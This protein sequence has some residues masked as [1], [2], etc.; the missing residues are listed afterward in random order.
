MLLE[1]YIVVTPQR[2]RGLALL[3]QM[4]LVA[5]IVRSRNGKIICS[6]SA[7]TFHF[8]HHYKTKK[9]NE[10]FTNTSTNG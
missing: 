6:N 2:C 1:S 9:K 5:F 4:I 7:L 10:H 3:E 8:I